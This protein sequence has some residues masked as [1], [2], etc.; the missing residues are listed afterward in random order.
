M[1]KLLHIV[2]ILS[3]LKVEGQ[4]LVP[5]WS[6]ETYTSCPSSSGQ[7]PSAVPW[8]AQTSNSSD[9]YNACAALYSVPFKYLGQKRS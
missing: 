6:F 3:I 8:V 4:N 9:Y 2:L 7:L 5:N 1:K